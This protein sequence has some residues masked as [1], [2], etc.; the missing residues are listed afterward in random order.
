MDARHRPGVLLDH[1]DDAF[2]VRDLKIIE[3]VMVH[4]MLL[5]LTIAHSA[6][7]GSYCI[8]ADHG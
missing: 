8:S 3:G 6:A 1:V 5:Q 4:A 2:V 7:A